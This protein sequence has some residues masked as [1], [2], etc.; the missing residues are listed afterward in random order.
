MVK[1]FVLLAVALGIIIFFGANIQ[2]F[3]YETRWNYAVDQLPV[4][5][6]LKI[7]LKDVGQR[8]AKGYA[9]NVFGEIELLTLVDLTKEVREPRSNFTDADGRA[10]VGKFEAILKRHEL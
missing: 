8:V 10:V 4:A 9:R 1:T 3:I 6:E 5:A 2:G 7:D